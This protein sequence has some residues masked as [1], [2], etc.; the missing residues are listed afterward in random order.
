M[1]LVGSPTLQ[2]GQ[3]NQKWPTSGPCGYIAPATWGSPTLHS[4]GQNQKW[5]KSWPFGHIII[6]ARGVPNPSER[7]RKPVVAHKWAV[8]LHSSCCLGGPERFRGGDKISRWPKGRHIGYV[9]AISA[10]LVISPL[11]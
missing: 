5:L 1:P 7:G 3:Q 9:H 4:H 10:K 11:L 8:W 6:A 2:S